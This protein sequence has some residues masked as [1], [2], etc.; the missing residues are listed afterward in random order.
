[1]IVAGLIV[2][3]L[4]VNAVFLARIGAATRQR[5]LPAPGQRQALPPAPN[6]FGDLVLPDPRDPRWRRKSE[7]G[8]GISGDQCKVVMM[9]F[10]DV[11][12]CP[13]H[14]V[15]VDGLDPKISLPDQGARF[16]EY[17][18]L[19]RLGYIANRSEELIESHDPTPPALPAPETLPIS[20]T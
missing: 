4:L 6:V 10:G 14:G 15:R 5:R 3:A 17:V 13:Q 2:F 1:L 7:L 11:H 18:K 12:V 9:Q 16:D 8:C 19:V 20:S